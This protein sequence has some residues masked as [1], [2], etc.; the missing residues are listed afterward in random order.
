MTKSPTQYSVLAF[1]TIEEANQFQDICEGLMLELAVAGACVCSANRLT[2]LPDGYAGYWAVYY[3]NESAIRVIEGRGVPVTVLDTVSEVP[4]TAGV[5]F[6]PR[7]TAI[8]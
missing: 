7:R 8:D 2:G 1:K 4:P 5:D 3:L 6:G